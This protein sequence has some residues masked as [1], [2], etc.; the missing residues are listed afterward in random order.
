MEHA[1]SSAK[2]SFLGKELE[3]ETSRLLL[4]RRVID[5]QYAALKMMEK[6]E[7]IDL[8]LEERM[9]YKKRMI[10]F[11][12]GSCSICIKPAREKIG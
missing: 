3:H 4:L 8:A 10:T 2:I 9:W 7:D 12:Q 1:V 11:V 5:V 6:L